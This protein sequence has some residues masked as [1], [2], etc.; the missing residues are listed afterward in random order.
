M[1]TKTYKVFKKIFFNLLMELKQDYWCTHTGVDGYLYLLFQ[2][3]YFKLTTY[4]I[5]ISFLAQFILVIIDDSFEF[6]IFGD[7]S[8]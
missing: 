6:S 2:R 3:R 8:L 7:L 4:M 1:S 5:W